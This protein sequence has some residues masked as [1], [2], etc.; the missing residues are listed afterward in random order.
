MRASLPLL[1]AVCALGATGAWATT[2]T[3]IYS[4]SYKYISSPDAGYD[5]SILTKST[6]SIDFI[7]GDFPSASVN[8]TGDTPLLVGVRVEENRLGQTMIGNGCGVSDSASIVLQDLKAQ[9]P[10]S[11]DQI[12]KLLYS[13]V[14][15]PA[16]RAAGCMRLHSQR[17]AGSDDLS[18]PLVLY[19]TPPTSTMALERVS[20]TSARPWA[21][22]TSAPM[23]TPTM[24][25]R[26]AARTSR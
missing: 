13:Q 12:M 5:P 11:Y 23:S 18:L 21:P 1:L 19:R 6:I 8:A 20:Y 16:R 7:D 2:I 10:D 4:T 26:I 24:I 14:S 9:H 25:P 3:E 15:M 17:R 22:P